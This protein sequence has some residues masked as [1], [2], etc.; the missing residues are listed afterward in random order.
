MEMEV[1]EIALDSISVSEFNVRK[2]LEAGTEDAGIRDLANSIRENGL[3][4]PVIV[5][6]ATEGR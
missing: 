1:R 5:R 2:D 4:S 3:N 6:T